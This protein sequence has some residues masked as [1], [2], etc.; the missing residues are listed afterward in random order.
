MP[1]QSQ[2]KFPVKKRTTSVK[3]S[4]K[5]HENA[6]PG[7]KTLGVKRALFGAA[8]SPAAS[9]KKTRISNENV[10]LSSTPTKNKNS[11]LSEAKS[12]FHTGLPHRLIGRSKEIADIHCFLNGHIDG[13]TSGSLYISG[14]PGTLKPTFLF[15]SH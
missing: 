1:L 2:L 14:A 13:K 10:S 8:E 4:N 15:T 7:S 5:L 6:D 12:A 9:P 11:C 3:K